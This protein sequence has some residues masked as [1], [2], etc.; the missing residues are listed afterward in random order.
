[1]FRLRTVDDSIGQ[2]EAAR[3]EYVYIPQTLAEK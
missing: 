1:M 2:T 3:H